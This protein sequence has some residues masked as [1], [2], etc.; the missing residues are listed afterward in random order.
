M[1]NLALLEG[2]QFSHHHQWL[3]FEWH[4]KAQT[5]ICRV[6]RHLFSIRSQQHGTPAETKPASTICTR[7]QIANVSQQPYRLNVSL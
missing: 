7:A 1:V 5:T 3:S 4:S 6:K 2:N